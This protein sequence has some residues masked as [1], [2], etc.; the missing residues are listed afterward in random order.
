MLLDD[1]TPLP[2]LVAP[3]GAAD[4]QT[5]YRVVFTAEGVLEVSPWNGWPDLM[6][7]IDD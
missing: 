3:G 5:D 2:A 4:L 1:E 7:P 6:I